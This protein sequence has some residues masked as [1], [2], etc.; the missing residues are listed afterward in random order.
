MKGCAPKIAGIGCVFV[1]LF[2]AVLLFAMLFSDDMEES[3]EPV[4]RI[5][6]PSLYAAYA[7]NEIEADNK[8]K[9]KYGPYECKDKITEYLIQKGYRYTDIKNIKE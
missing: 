8:Y 3:K 6:A 9:D 1:L 7:K 4:A 5:S 2:S